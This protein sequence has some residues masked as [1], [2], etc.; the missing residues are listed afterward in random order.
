MAHATSSPSTRHS[1][2]PSLV[3]DELAKG[4]KKEL[5]DKDK[6]QKL[7]LQVKSEVEECIA[8]L[9]VKRESDPYRNLLPRMM[10]QASHGW[11]SEIPT[12]DL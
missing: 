6:A 10:Y 1:L 8:Y 2:F 7:Y 5:K 12:F 4:K 11:S 3:F 9:K